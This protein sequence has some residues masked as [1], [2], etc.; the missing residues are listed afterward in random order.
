MQFFKLQNIK[1]LN[2]QIQLYQ[3][4]FFIPKLAFST[5]LPAPPEKAGWSTCVQGETEIELNKEKGRGTDSD[6]ELNLGR[7]NFS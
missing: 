6:V 3:H 7:K 2:S 4:E 5:H 1:I